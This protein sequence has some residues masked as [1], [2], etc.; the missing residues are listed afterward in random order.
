[1]L[2]VCVPDDEFIIRKRLLVLQVLSVH[3]LLVP[4]RLLQRMV[5]TLPESVRQQQHERY[6]RYGAPEH[7]THD[8]LLPGIVLGA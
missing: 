6:E 2:R 5:Q 1:M 3:R 8:G 7:C 4:E